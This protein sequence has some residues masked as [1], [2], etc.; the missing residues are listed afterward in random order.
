MQFKSFIYSLYVNWFGLSF[1]PWFQFWSLPL[2]RTRCCPG[3][4]LVFW[5]GQSTPY[6]LFLSFSNPIWCKKYLH[7][8]TAFQWKFMLIKDLAVL[9]FHIWENIAIILK[10][11]SHYLL[12]K[13]GFYR[14]TSRVAFGKWNHYITINCLI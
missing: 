6:F 5:R 11:A 13:Y 8:Q 12:E 3:V 14:K 2:T 7:L 10:I 1:L 4:V 9:S